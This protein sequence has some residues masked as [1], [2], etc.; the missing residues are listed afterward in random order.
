MRTRSWKKI[1]SKH[2]GGPPIRSPNKSVI[3][4]L[5]RK[6]CNEVLA[7]FLLQIVA[8]INP[9]FTTAMGD[10]TVTA[11]AAEISNALSRE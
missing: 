4:N 1:S 5:F 9:F 10:K 8:K 6:I 11:A 2:E 7:K 3:A